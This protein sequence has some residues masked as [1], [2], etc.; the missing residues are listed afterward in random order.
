[1][2]RAISDKTSENGDKKVD[3]TIE[4]ADYSSFKV[5]DVDK[6][7]STGFLTFHDCEGRITRKDEEKKVMQTAIETFRK[8][9]PKSL[10][11]IT[12]TINAAT[13]EVRRNIK[14]L[15]SQ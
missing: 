6:T 13:Q 10:R 1:M 5:V 12:S 8:E 7:N 9:A 4:E 3:L 14:V 15:Q 2:F 11:V